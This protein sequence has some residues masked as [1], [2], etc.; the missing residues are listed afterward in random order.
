M[1]NDY[2][3]IYRKKI[4][5]KIDDTKHSGTWKVAYADFITAMMAFFMLLWLLSVTPEESLQGIA[6]YFAVVKSG[7]KN[8]GDGTAESHKSESSKTKQPDATGMF[9]DTEKQHFLD[10]MNT[11]QKSSELQEYLENITVDI[12]DEGLRIQIMDSNNRPVFK[13]D[14]YQL[15]PYMSKILTV[16]GKMIKDQPNYLVLSGHTASIK[17][18]DKNQQDSSWLL[19]SMRANEIRKF[20]TS[21]ILKDDQILRIIGKSDK[22]PFD[23][24]DKYSLKNIRV[25]IT[26][27]ANSSISGFQQSTP[28]G[29][30]QK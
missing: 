26:L 28:Y 17:D 11:I 6:Q 21:K 5:K 1:A 22:E 24:K 14:T 15:Q 20:L 30:Q 13:P 29:K 27:L 25:T 3:I 8:V 2:K 19:S 16:I 12:T 18:V 7:G 4:I 10:I 23:P 9:S